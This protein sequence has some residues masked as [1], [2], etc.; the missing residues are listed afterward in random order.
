MTTKWDEYMKLEGF[1]EYY[2]IEAYQY[3]TDELERKKVIAQI[4][5]SKNA[6]EAKAIIAKARREK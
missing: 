4:E 2:V 1:Q 6:E 3:V 5:D